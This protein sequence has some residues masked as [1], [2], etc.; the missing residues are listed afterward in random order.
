MGL[1]YKSGSIVVGQTRSNAIILGENNTPVGITTGS[2]ITG[3]ALTFL[4]SNDN[5]TYLPL[6]NSDST[7][8]SLTVTTAARSYELQPL[9]TWGWRFM[10]I[11][12]GNSAS[13]VAQ[14]TVDTLFT[15]VTRKLI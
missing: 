7:E 15:V 3:T 4:V 14:A 1:N 5:I 12:E 6:Y 13:S 2:N 10:K 11:R 9:E 8:I